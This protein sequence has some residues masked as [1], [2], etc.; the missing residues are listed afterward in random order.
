[1][2]GSFVPEQKAARPRVNYTV[3]TY[4]TFA[5]KGPQASEESRLDNAESQARLRALL[6]YLRDHVE[7][8]GPIR[9][10]KHSL[11]GLNP[12]GQGIAVIH[13]MI[14]VTRLSVLDRLREEA[15]RPGTLND[16]LNAVRERLKTCATE[17]LYESPLASDGTS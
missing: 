13:V 15:E 4:L 2:T 9:V 12:T 11:G 10:F 1:M 7:G 16:L 8:V 5:H 17:I 6:R 14:E 3:A